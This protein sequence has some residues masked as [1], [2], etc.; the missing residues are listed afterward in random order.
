[1]K[2]LRQGILL[3]ILSLGF[4][5]VLYP[6]FSLVEE[7]YEYVEVFGNEDDT[8]TQKYE[9]NGETTYLKNPGEDFIA[10]LN[11]KTGEVKFRSRLWEMLKQE[12]E[13]N[14]FSMTNHVS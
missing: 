9:K 4:W 6:Q 5:G 8:A 12:E 13:R 7:T 3:C 1:M 2:T 10:I 14:R 11:A